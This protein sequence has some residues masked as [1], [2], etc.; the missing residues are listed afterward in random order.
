MVERV[1]AK[2][3]AKSQLAGNW[4]PAILAFFVL[5]VA[6][7]GVSMISAFVPFGFVV[8]IALMGI[9][10][11]GMAF[12]ALKYANNA[13]RE[14]GDVF[15]AFNDFKTTFCLTFLIG[16]YTVLWSLLLIVPGI[17]KAYSYSMSYYILAENPGMTASEAI[18]KSKEM[19]DGHK[20]D[21]FVTDLSF[22]G[23]GLLASLSLGIGYLWLVPYRNITMAN[24]Y[25][26]IKGTNVNN[27][28]VNFEQ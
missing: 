4:G 14:L 19:T 6:M 24:I 5:G 3:A 28:E 18:Q 2:Q 23:W 7:F 21:L 17:I 25:N 22:I 9:A 15:A 20:L 12:Y 11:F 8:E 26:Q 16:L 27:V 13:E 1:A 10:P